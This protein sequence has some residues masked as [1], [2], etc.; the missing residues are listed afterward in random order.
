MTARFHLDDATLLAQT[1]YGL[2]GSILT[3]WDAFAQASLS[4][5]ARPPTLATIAEDLQRDGRADIAG[6]TLTLFTV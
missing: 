3:T 2:F 5:G 4:D 1:R 6:G